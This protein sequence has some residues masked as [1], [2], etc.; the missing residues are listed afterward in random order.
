MMRRQVMQKGFPAARFAAARAASGLVTVAVLA[1][2]GV[3][4]A[5]G[6]RRPSRVP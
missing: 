1:T 2:G 5:G 3:A 6:R 4:L